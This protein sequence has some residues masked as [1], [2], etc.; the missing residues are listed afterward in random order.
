MENFIAMKIPMKRRF[1]IFVLLIGLATSAYILYVPY[2]FTIGALASIY[3]RCAQP[4]NSIIDSNFLSRKS[5]FDCIKTRNEIQ[6]NFSI[7]SSNQHQPW[8][9]VFERP[10]IA[11]SAY[12]FEKQN[13]VKVL[14]LKHLDECRPVVC[15]FHTKEGTLA[16]KSYGKYF[17]KIRVIVIFFW[18]PRRFRHA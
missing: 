5:N 6:Q 4:K 13:L 2:D 18:I 16:G 15:Y 14:V 9:S 1:I 10:I 3:V 12:Y 8:I 17:G 7:S 11:Y